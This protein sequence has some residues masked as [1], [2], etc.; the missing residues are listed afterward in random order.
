MTAFTGADT[1]GRAL[2]IASTLA[3]ALALAACSDSGSQIGEGAESLDLALRKV[4]TDHQLNR[5]P[6][7]NRTIPQI[8]DP[9]PQ[10]GKELFFTKAL[11]G[12]MDS[13]CVSC[14]HPTLGGADDLTLPI[15]VDAVAP[16]ILGKGRSHPSGVPNVPR[17]SPT[18]FNL[19][20]WDSVLFWDSRVESLSK[21]PGQNG[22]GGG[23]RTPDVVFGTSDPDAGGNLAT[24]QA[25]F[26][27]TSSEEMKTHSFENGS[28]NSQIRDH[29]AQRLGNYG[30]AAAELPP[31]DWLNAFQAAFN[32]TDTAENLITY[33]NIALALAEYER[34]MVFVNTPWS[35]FA[36]GDDSALNAD[37]KNG[38][39][40]F[41]SSVQDGGAGCVNCHAGPFFTN[42]LN[43]TVAFPQIGQGKGDDNGQNDKDDFGRERVTADPADRYRFRVPSLINVATTAPYGHAGAYETLEEVVR[44]YNNPQASVDRFFADGGVCQLDQFD[45]LANCATLYPHAQT[46]SNLAVA[47]LRQEQ[48]QGVS[49]LQNP[50]LNEQEIGQVAAFLRAL[51]DPCVT[52]RACLTP[53]I[54]NPASA[55]RDGLQLNA[56]DASLNPL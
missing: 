30:A 12:G 41:F 42:E 51:T 16:D 53:W 33:D 46:N 23:I 32:S 36:A 20:L 4:V 24:A 25:R 45:G 56:T 18:V 40:L 29:L 8:T 13:A 44:H 21:T 22:A 27:V 3:A 28:P 7:A 10:L 55:G 15:G 11:G 35:R 9:L 37:E 1:H 43:T 2:R 47:K 54:A 34:S 38:A 31:T 26:P 17:N 5:D 49:L 6:L 48:Q 50:Q 19:A 14:H 52:D 39:I